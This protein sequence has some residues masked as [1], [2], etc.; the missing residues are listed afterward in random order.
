MLLHP[1]NFPEAKTA[2][3][4]KRPAILVRADDEDSDALAAE[5]QAR[6][7]QQ[8][9]TEALAPMRRE[10]IHLLQSRCQRRVLTM[11]EGGDAADDLPIVIGAKPEPK[12]ETN[13][14][15]A[16]ATHQRGASASPS[17]SSFSTGT[18]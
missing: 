7:L 2:V 1:G 11:M 8:R 6:A 17:P 5:V 12:A 14:P 3:P 13:R 15:L 16:R 9:G 18:R 10:D 4:T